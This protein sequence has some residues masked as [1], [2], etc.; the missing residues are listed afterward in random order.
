MGKRDN[1]FLDRIDICDSINRRER[2]FT[3][4]KLVIN[5]YLKYSN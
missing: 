4:K 1:S 5:H 2:K 3:Y